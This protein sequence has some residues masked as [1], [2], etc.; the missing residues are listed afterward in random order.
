MMTLIISVGSI[1]ENRLDLLESKIP[2]RRTD[3]G[4]ASI[5]LL[6]YCAICDFEQHQSLPCVKGGGTA[7]P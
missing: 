2:I 6:V 7:K 5:I 4:R 1:V 3:K